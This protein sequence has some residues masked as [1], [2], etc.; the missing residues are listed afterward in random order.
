MTQNL[1]NNI[2]EAFISVMN[3]YMPLSQEVIVSIGDDEPITV[4]EESVALKLRQISNSILTGC[5]K[6]TP[7]YSHLLLQI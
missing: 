4:T 6:S 2:N 5:S 3:D 7:T 1:V